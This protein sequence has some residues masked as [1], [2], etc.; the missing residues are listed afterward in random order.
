MIVTIDGPAGAGKSSVS[1]K[2]A[3]RIGFQFLDTGAMYRAVTW[4]AIQRNVDLEHGD[5]VGLAQGIEIV[6]Q[7]GSV[8]VD[9]EDV[10]DAIRATDVTRGVSEIADNPNIR[11][12]MV[13]LQRKIAGSGDYVCEGRDQGT[14]AFPGAACKIFLTASPGERAR[15]RCL[16]L[17]ETGVKADLGE[18]FAAQNERDRRDATRSVGALVK[19]SDA[20]EVVTDGRTFNEVVDELVAIVAKKVDR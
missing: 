13:D 19:A 2:L 16:Q 18:V 12:L 11:A 14:V 5:V 20:I 10:S 9:G 4:L 17:Q 3:D 6:F 8:C 15:R 1:R 7:S